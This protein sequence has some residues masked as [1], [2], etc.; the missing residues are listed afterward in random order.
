KL[1][2]V[3]RLLDEARSY[4]KAAAATDVRG[5]G[6]PGVRK[7]WKL[8]ALVPIVE[9][10]APLVTRATTERDIRDAVAFADR[11]HVNIVISGGLEAAPVAQLLKEK[12]VPV[13][14]GSILTLPPRE[15]LPH[16][17][18]YAA[19]GELVK[20]GVKI[21]FATGDADNTRQLP[22]QA[23]LSVAWGLPRDEAL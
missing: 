1:D 15:D 8:E 3:A 18:S 21:A 12:N 17:A 4:A 16:Q 10:R 13:I 11:V 19:A 2:E 22:Y 5:A 6:A 9:R 14:L 23:A 7:D 20:A